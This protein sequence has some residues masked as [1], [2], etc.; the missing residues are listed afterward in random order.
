M[1]SATTVWQTTLGELEVT[2]SKA[3]FT[4]WFRNTRIISVADGL[5]TLGV[6][7]TFA[8]EWLQSKYH[9]EIIASLKQYYPDIQ[10]VEYLVATSTQRPDMS[11]PTPA[12]APA[13]PTSSAATA[14][15]SETQRTNTSSNTLNERYT[16]DTFI[17]GNSN[18]LAH[19]AALAIVKKPGNIQYN[20][21]YVYGGVG[22]GK[23]HLL[24][25]IGNEIQKQFPK[26][27]ILYASCERFT[28]EF[29]QAMQSKQIDSFKKRYRN[30][31]V[32]LIDD[33]QFLAG[34]EGTQEEFFHTFNT[35]HQTNRQI[36]MTSDK[37]P[38]S[39]PQLEP[40][41]SSRF[42]WG[43]VTDM[44]TP[45]FET[46]QAILLHKCEEKS[47]PLDQE[48]IEYMAQH[49]QSNIRELEGALNAIA[50][51][52]EL[53][54]VQPSLKLIERVLEQTGMDRRVTHVTVESISQ[55]IADFFTLELV[56]LLGKR[57]NKELVYPRQIAMYLIR[58]ELQFSYPKIGKALG[59]KD[60]TTVMHGVEKI[61]KELVHD[62]TLQRDIALIK[63]RLYVAG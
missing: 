6:P 61:T 40:R 25:A 7:H 2:L 56:D 27:T 9:K 19:A 33:I 30:A 23:T 46:R 34:K 22:L 63:E 26:K 51:H 3:N 17:V 52:C 45:D 62:D 47:F 20:P 49:V 35:L 39:I 24:H 42:G 54:N 16:F 21:L 55:T 41:L 44:Q 1:Q 4:T 14:S 12:T 18:R 57:R 60:H 58:T 15:S 31:D 48:V 11:E 10:R 53:Y 13:A 38:R 59:G 8:K 37:R 28:S 36:I 32:L 50:T 43:M 5:V 29:V